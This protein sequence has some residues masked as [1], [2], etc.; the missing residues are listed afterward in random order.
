MK[1]GLKKTFRSIG[2]FFL[3]FLSLIFFRIDWFIFKNVVLPAWENG[4]IQINE[5]LN[6]L[7]FQF[8]DNQAY[9]PILFY[10]SLALLF[11]FL[12]IRKFYRTWI[13]NS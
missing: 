6:I 7:S 11:L 10:L 12:G 1:P 3:L 5:E 2:V 4:T 9:I 8:H 13:K